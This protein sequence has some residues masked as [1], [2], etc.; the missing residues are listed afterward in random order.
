MACYTASVIRPGHI[1]F[2]KQVSQHLKAAGITDIFI[3]GYDGSVSEKTVDGR[4]V[5]SCKQTLW[6]HDSVE[7]AIDNAPAPSNAT[8]AEDVRRIRASQAA[9]DFYI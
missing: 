3:R 2:A 7:R 5:S 4:L 8:A 9:I 6:Q 1:P